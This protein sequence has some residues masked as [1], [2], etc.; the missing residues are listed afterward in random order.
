VVEQKPTY[1]ELE[2]LAKMAWGIAS[3][4]DPEDGDLAVWLQRG[5]D[6]ISEVCASLAVIYGDAAMLAWLRSFSARERH[7][8]IVAR[9][10]EVGP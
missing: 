6:A 10:R 8:A 3:G 7:A 4:P 9:A 2:L 5:R 1:E